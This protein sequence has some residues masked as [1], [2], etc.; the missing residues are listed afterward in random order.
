[1]DE[2]KLLFSFDD[3]EEEEAAL[4]VLF[5]DDDDVDEVVDEE[6]AVV[7]R[8]FGA[9]VESSGDLNDDDE[10]PRMWCAFKMS[11]MCCTIRLIATVFSAP[12]GI[13]TS[14]YFFVGKQNSSKAGLTNFW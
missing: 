6:I 4:S 11:L 2:R 13:M 5:D 7:G 8:L 1:M 3:D 9:I 14:A 10:S 12:R